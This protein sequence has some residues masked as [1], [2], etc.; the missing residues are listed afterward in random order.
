[1]TTHE[2]KGINNTI[3]R[4]CFKIIYKKEKKERAFCVAAIAS[5]VS[6]TQLVKMSSNYKGKIQLYISKSL[7]SI[8]SLIM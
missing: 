6:N 3:M 2:F 4:S 8:T 1:M 5:V 7:G